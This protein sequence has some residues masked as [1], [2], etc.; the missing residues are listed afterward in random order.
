MTVSGT[1][2]FMPRATEQLI[3]TAAGALLRRVNTAVRYMPGRGSVTAE[4]DDVM[5]TNYM[6]DFVAVTDS[7]M[8]NRQD[9]SVFLWKIHA[10]ACTVSKLY[11][12]ATV[13]ATA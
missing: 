8:T 9:G 4:P 13:T 1:S 7:L 11:K 3:D 10:A 6:K 5:A 2:T 12:I